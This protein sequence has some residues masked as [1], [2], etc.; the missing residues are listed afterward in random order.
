MDDLQAHIDLLKV[1]IKASLEA[2]REDEGITKEELLFRLGVIIGI[3]DS[4][5]RAIESQGG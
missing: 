5:T 1:E 2:V 3:S 4:L